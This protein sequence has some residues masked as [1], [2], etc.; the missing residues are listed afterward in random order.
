MALGL[1][2]GMAC[3]Q[4]KKRKKAPPVL[5]FFLRRAVAYSQSAYDAPQRP[6]TL[7][8]P[9][10]V[11]TARPRPGFAPVPSARSTSGLPLRRELAVATIWETGPA[12]AYHGRA[13]G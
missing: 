5:A 8:L 3:Q 7:G 2:E 6:S 11:R 9:P 1:Y 12:C 13:P 4:K 10:P